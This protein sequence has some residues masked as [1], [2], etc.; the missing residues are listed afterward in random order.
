M[1]IFDYTDYSTYISETLKNRAIA[2]GSMN[3][4]AND[5]GYKKSS[6]IS[7]IISG[8][9]KPSMDFIHRF[10]EYF[11]LSISEKNDLESKLWGIDKDKGL[12]QVY[13]E[14]GLCQGLTHWLFLFILNLMST[15]GTCPD[16]FALAKEFNEDEKLLKKIVK[17][18]HVLKILKPDESGRL[19]PKAI[20]KISPHSDLLKR[21]KIEVDFIKLVLKKVNG[22]KVDDHFIA[23]EMVN[24]DESR[25]EEAQKEVSD[26][27]L[28]FQKKYY[29]SGPGVMHRLNA[30]LFKF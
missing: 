12:K 23:G 22:Q 4:V 11:N 18:I 10:S 7:M 5:L 27:L 16:T 6:L 17:D 9:R 30:Q 13:L 15:K 2:L 19:G 8:K 29:Y 20:F 26:F 14:T 25:V 24:I 28:S 3:E 1:N 21:K